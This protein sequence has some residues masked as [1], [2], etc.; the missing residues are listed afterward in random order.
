MA[1]ST[2]NENQVIQRAPQTDAAIAAGFVVEVKDKLATYLPEKVDRDKFLTSVFLAFDGNDTLMSALKTPQGRSSVVSAL[3]LAACKG[4]SLNPQ[5]G[6]AGFVPYK[7]Q[8]TYRVF[9]A[10]M[11]ELAIRDGHLKEM[12]TRVIYAN[13]TLALGEDE[14]GDTYRLERAVDNPGDLRGFLAVG[15]LPDN[16]VRTH[17]MTADQVAEWGERYG[18]RNKEGRLSPMWRESFEGAG[19]KTVAR[20]LLSKLHVSIPGL[21]EPEEEERI[22]AYV[23]EATSEPAPARRGRPPK[24]TAPADLTAALEAKSKSRQAPATT[25]DTDEDAPRDALPPGEPDPGDGY[26]NDPDD[27]GELF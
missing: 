14:H 4:L 13:D 10:G 9:A 6:L 2:Q 11:I 21:E 5:E 17:Y 24:G 26:T 1:K 15:R 7:G 3:R 8:I 25:P 19:Q 27:D 20:Q 18:T 23:I 12:R 22:A 16:T